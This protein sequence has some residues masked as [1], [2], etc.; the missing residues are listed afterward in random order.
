MLLLSVNLSGVTQVVNATLSGTAADTTG[1]LIPG[2]EV[3]ARQTGTGVVSTTVTNESGAYRFSSLQP[4]PYEVSAA[5]PGFQTQTFRLTLGT[6]QQIRQNFSL[7]VGAVAQAVEVSVAADELLTTQTASVGTA[8][9]QAQVVDLPLVGRNVMD[10]AT[11]IMP[12]VVGD[13][14][15]NTTFAGIPAI[16]A[17][18]VGIAM[19]GTTMNA[20]R[21]SHGLLIPLSINPDMVEE[22]RVVVAA[23]DAEG[24]G[25]AQV[26]MRSRS[27][28]NTFRG[29]L[30]WNIRNSALNANEWSNNRLGIAPIWY[31]RHQYT[32]SVGGPIVR[33]K[34]FFFA[35]F[36]G[37]DGQQREN[38]NALVLTDTARQGIFR[39]FPGVNSGHADTTPSGSGNSRI[40]PV[41]DLGGNPR[42]WTQIPGATGPMQSFNVFGDALNPGD[43]NRRRI[44]STGFISRLIDRMPRANAFDTN[45]D[46]LNTAV[47]RWIR[48]TVAGPAGFTGENADAFR[49]RQANV[50][51]DHNFDANHRLTG[52]FIREVRYTDNMPLL[53]AWPSGWDGE[54]REDPTLISA[55]LT[56]TLSPRVLNEFRYGYR[57]TTLHYVPGFLA[58]DHGK[59]AYDF[60]TQVNGT[61]IL[62][63]P[64]LFG[65]HVL[66]SGNYS[67]NTS[68]LSTY[69][70]T[71]S[72]TRGSHAFKAGAELRMARSEGWTAGLMP[73]VTGG[74]GD[75]PVRGI[76]TIPGLLPSNIAL[77]Q[78]LLLFMSGSVASVSQ[79]FQTREPTDTAYQEFR[80]L[81]FHPENPKDR[82]GVVRVFQQNEFNFFVKD[83]WRVTPSFTLNL[84]L[85]YDLF[86]VPYQR[87]IS[88]QNWTTSILGGNEGVYGYSGRSIDS[89]M[90]GGSAQK[91]ELTELGL[92]GK[93]TAFPNQGIWPSDRNNF[94]PA[95]GFAWSPNWW[96]Q[97]RTTIRGGY[98]IAYQ[99]PGNTI[100]WISVDTGALGLSYTATDRG[101]GS[102]YRDFANLTIPLPLTQRPFVG[103]IPITSR[104]PNLTVF[105][106]DYTTPYVQTFTLGLTRSVASNL[107][108][109]VKYVG[110]RGIK[111][112]S[113]WNLNDADF[114]NNGLY[115]ALQIT[116]AGGNAEL[117]D[118]ML[119]GL[120]IGSGVIGTAISGSE[121]L[122]QHASFRTAIANGDYVA[123]AQTLN[124]TNIGTVQPR[125]QLIGGGTMR[126]SGL[127]PENFFVV[128]PQFGSITYRSNADNS[129]YHSLQTQVTLRPTHGINYQGTYTWSR[130]LGVSNGVGTTGNFQGQYRDLLNQRADYGLLASH[131]L[132]DFRSYG[133]FELPFGPGR[134]LGGNS[135]G[136]IARLI[137]GWRFGTIFNMTSGAPLNIAGG[138]TL[139]NLGTPD[140][141]GAFPREG[142]VV[143]PVASGAAFGNY[144]DQQY[145][146]VP[147]PACATVASSL[148][149]WC[150]NT[151]LADANGNIVLRNAGPGELGT[152]GLYTIAGPGRWDLDANVQKSIRIDES[153]NLILR[154][155]ARNLFNH[156]S[157]GNPSLNIN[158]G[159]FGEINSKTGNRT[160]AAQLRLEF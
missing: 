154:V 22:V 126:S 1:A 138:R 121:A 133:S 64:A 129:I 41:V 45:G 153:R 13:G 29:G 69:T 33:N 81:Y 124:T 3:T 67:G 148:T 156:P 48:R 9:P 53:A 66:P 116:R 38:V 51:I 58:R 91:G 34:T 102:T 39:F 145:R 142:A 114:R 50:K 140:I 44:D 107:T 100:S 60:L 19:D 98:Q 49:R 46:G 63:S 104:S 36:D 120:N 76:D 40:A 71:L 47:H 35:L 135:S 23:V 6:A 7:Q 94:S 30:T 55:Q 21:H 93:G 42:D 112:L 18:N 95:V 2:V 65:T 59:E 137:E 14:R 11:T 26:Q 5:L 84:G 130:S 125:D 77:A 106:P 24:R 72:W 108:V 25:S 12:G 101:D 139:Y 141:A 80:D 70:N 99:L 103:S 17:G 87:S 147:D 136:W 37:Q 43:P 15:A 82:Y 83:D 97:D 96:G 105:S 155:D 109:D 152:L 27:G 115:E 157:P 57:V 128:N 10:L 127:F 143:W 20:G 110:T 113:S 146:R 54:I 92:I 150:T 151:A 62:Q 56:S 75:V 32:A 88:G 86:R 90:S 68:P 111:L 85:R 16:G 52:T 28:T 159:T 31:N 132:H 149:R 61:P 144:F 160:L 158:S 123:V 119:R 79:T 78:N 89:W 134:L 74:A 118:R 73:T 122:R 131:R 117:F 4:G 8:L